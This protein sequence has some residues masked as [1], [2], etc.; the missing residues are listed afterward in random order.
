MKENSD[1][2]IE[3]MRVKLHTWGI[4]SHTREVSKRSFLAYIFK[5]S[6]WD[7]QENQSFRS[8]EFQHTIFA[9]R[10]RIF[11]PDSLHVSIQHDEGSP[12]QFRTYHEIFPLI[13]EF[14]RYD[15]SYRLKLIGIVY[16]FIQDSCERLIRDT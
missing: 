14:N 5:A 7:H 16:E 12:P 11:L 3:N 13:F 1:L 8:Y 15:H 6:E 2:R 4:P 9:I 10:F